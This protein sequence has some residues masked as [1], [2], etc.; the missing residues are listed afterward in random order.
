M[1][2]AEVEPGSGGRV[3]KNYLGIKRK[4]VMYRVEWKNCCVL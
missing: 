1:I 2:E 3:L 4:R